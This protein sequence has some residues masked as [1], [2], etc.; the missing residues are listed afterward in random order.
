VTCTGRLESFDIPFSDAADAGEH[1]CTIGIGVECVKG[2][3]PSRKCCLAINPLINKTVRLQ[4]CLDE[5]KHL[6]PKSKNNTTDCQLLSITFLTEKS[7]AFSQVCHW[8][9][10]FQAAALHEDFLKVL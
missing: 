7:R 5:I 6:G 10:S 8:N 9:Q 4:G 3:D 1:N 2:F